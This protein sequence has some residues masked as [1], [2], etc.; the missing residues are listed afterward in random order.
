MLPAIEENISVLSTPHGSSLAVIGGDFIV[1]IGVPVF[2]FV[3]MVITVDCKLFGKLANVFMLGGWIFGFDTKEIDDGG[4]RLT[5]QDVAVE[6]PVSWDCND[7][8]L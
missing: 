5:Y 4:G 3:G 1:H 8:T 2:E 6:S 7:D